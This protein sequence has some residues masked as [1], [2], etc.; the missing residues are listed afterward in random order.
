MGGNHV[1]VTRRLR[2]VDIPLV[3]DVDAHRA[4]RVA[5]E[6]GAEW[7]TSSSVLAGEVDTAVIAVPTHLHRHVGVPLAE[8]GIHILVEKPLAGTLE[9]AQAL[10][11]AARAN[12]VV[13]M[14]GHVE[15]FNT[16]ILE[17]DRWLD[18]VIHVEATRVGP[19]SGRVE[20]GVIFDLMIHDLDI[21]RQIIPSP[22]S[23]VQA[24]RQNP[25][26]NTEDLACALF[27]FENGATANI[28][29]SRI[30]QNKVRRLEITQGSS[31][32]SVDLLRQDVMIRR[33]AQARFFASPDPTYQQSGVVEIPFL[34]NRGE[35]LLLEVEHFFDCIAQTRRP[36]VGGEDGLEAVR[37]ALRVADASG[38]AVAP[39][40]RVG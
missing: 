23:E 24:V 30:G 5:A 3:V 14:V 26:S 29:A 13:L 7:E 34:A 28:T 38:E 39:R 35:P 15:R 20:E 11:D 33:M 8:A 40:R 21:V 17:L 16:A 18:D 4:Q 31:T 25:A 6:I 12:D 22:I 37:W 32:I 9:D 27:R 10:V 2:N 1:R 36:M 19:F